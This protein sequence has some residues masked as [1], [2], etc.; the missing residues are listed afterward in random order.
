VIPGENGW[1]SPAG[2]VEDLVDAMK[3]CLAA[4]SEQLSKMGDSG[5]RRVIERHA[6]DSEAAKLGALFRA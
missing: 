3:S 1:L 2:S 6:I 4:D 5:Y